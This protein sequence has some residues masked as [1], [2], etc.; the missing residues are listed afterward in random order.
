MFTLTRAV[1]INRPT[2]ENRITREHVWT[3]LARKAR[4]GRAFVPGM[5]MC[6]VVEEGATS[7]VRELAV[8]NGPSFRERVTLHNEK[9]VIFEHMDAPQT[10]VVL[11]QIETDDAGEYLLRYTFLLEFTDVEHGSP[12]EAARREHAAKLP[13]AVDATLDAIHR[14]VAAGEL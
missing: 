2:D 6:K 10:S 7:F 12:E 3:A 8:N 1:P 11:N 9:L 13:F 5:T 14:M 4:D